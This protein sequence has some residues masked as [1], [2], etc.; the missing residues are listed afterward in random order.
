MPAA[1]AIIEEKLQKI[2]RHQQVLMELAH[3]STFETPSSKLLQ[4]AVGLIGGAI[5]VGHVKVLQ[6]RAA[7]ADLLVVAGAGWKDGVVNQATFAVDLASPPGR[8]FQTGQPVV[9]NGIAQNGEYRL[10]PVLRDHGIV[11][12]LNVPIQMDGAV[13]GVLEVDSTEHRDF[14]IDTKDFL[15]TAAS[16]LAAALRR[17]A[18]GRAHAAALAAAAQE[19]HRSKT[20]LLEMQHRMKNNFQTIVAMLA[21]HKSRLQGLDGQESLTRIADGVMAMALAHDQLAPTR[22]GEVVH[23]PTYLKALTTSIQ[24]PLEAITIETHADEINLIVERAVPVGLIVNE[25]VTNSVKHAFNERGGA[26]RVALTSASGTGR[27]RLIVTDNGR[28]MAQSQA[29]TGVRLIEALCL[30]LRGRLA[31]RSSD[32]GTTVEIAFAP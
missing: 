22:T 17:E 23:M 15:L 12:L 25:L 16:I 13:W 1:K 32:Q 10:S 29:G 4:D 24:K 9:I 20:L 27:V 11:S 28:G 2:R 5:E 14:S 21:I 8:A 19:G 18:V 7:T 30:Q 31:R 26:I 3:L 6:Y